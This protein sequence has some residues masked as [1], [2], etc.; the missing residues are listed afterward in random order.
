M[1][2]A[3]DDLL[4]DVAALRQADGAPLD[5]GFERDR[6]FVHVAMKE[7]HARFDPHGV[8]RRR[9]D[10][11]RA[12]VLQARVLSAPACARSTKRS[13]PGSPVSVTRV[14]I[15]GWPSDERLAGSPC[16]SS[17]DS[18]SAGHAVEHRRDR[19]SRRRGR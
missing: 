16:S 3:D 9:I 5:S 4:A 12:G 8:G 13:N 10:R 18:T 14:T 17:A 7:R 2:H 6:L 1:Q 15:A 11:R 19:P